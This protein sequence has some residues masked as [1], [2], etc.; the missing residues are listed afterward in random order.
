M[1]QIKK[2]LKKILHSFMYTIKEPI[3]IPMLEGTFLNGKTILITGGGTGIGKAI[4]EACLRN[5]ATVIIAGRNM[6]RLEKAK[7]EIIKTTSRNLIF[8]FIIDIGDVTSFE[9]T[10]KDISTLVPNGR[11]DILVNNAGVDAG[12]II[13]DTNETQYDMTVETNL[14]GTYF[15]SQAFAKYLLESKIKGNI[16]NISSVSG[17]RPVISPYMYSKW[18]ITGLTKGLAK[19]LIGY[20]IVVNGIAPGPTA[21]KMLGQDGSNLNYNNSPSKRFSD[22]NEIANLAVFLISDMG[23]MII[24][25]T[26]YITG[27]SGTLIFDDINYEM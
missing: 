17:N 22:P 11:I 4:A 10:I 8:T 24:G 14:K 2:T 13:P 27:G 3:Y 23:R 6:E 25:E 21:T 18:A 19:R 12:G 16:L 5:G 26:V 9:K 20:D 1:Q 15:L 7:A